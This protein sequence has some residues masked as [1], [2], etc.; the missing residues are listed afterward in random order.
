MQQIC[1]H[2]PHQRG[3]RYSVATASILTENKNHLIQLQKSLGFSNIEKLSCTFSN[4]HH[5]SSSLHVTLHLLAGTL[6]FT[7]SDAENV[8]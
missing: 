8:L 3:K 2:I 5:L 4:P 7:D 1:L 6:M